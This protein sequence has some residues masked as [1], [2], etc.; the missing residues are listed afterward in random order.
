MQL[1]WAPNV[2]NGGTRYE[3]QFREANIP[4]TTPF[5]ISGQ[6]SLSTLMECFPTIS[7][8]LQVEDVNNYTLSG[9]EPVTTYGVSIVC[10][11]P[12]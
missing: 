10:D 1:I 6:V 5:N 12:C 8:Y 3:I 11:F 4:D 7:V 2:G 9:L